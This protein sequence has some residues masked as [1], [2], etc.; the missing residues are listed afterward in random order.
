M[1]MCDSTMELNNILFVMTLLLYGAASMKSQAYFNKTGELPCHFTNSQNISLDELVVFWQD[2]DKLVLYELYR[3][4]EN[5]QNVHRK[6]KGRTSFD[7][8]NWTLRLHN[9]QIKD[10][11]LYQCFVH[12][13]GPKG[14]VPMHQM[15]SD[16]S[17]LANFSQPEIMVTS[18]RT[19]NSGIINLTCSSIQGYP[20]PK[21]MY[22]LVKT[23]N[24][25]TKYDTV[26]KKSQNNVT[27]LYNVSISLSFSVPEASNVSIFCV[28]Q[29]ESMKLPSLPYNI[30]AHTKPTPDG[31]HILWIAALLVMLVILCGMVFFLTLRKRKKKQPGPSHEC[32]T[33]KVERKESE[34][35]K[36]R[37]R[38]HE[39]ERSDEAQC[40]NISKTASGDNSTT[41]F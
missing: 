4:K 34:Q 33:N 41:Q 38:Y 18:N 32:E 6:Y 8:D 35:T 7:K 29:L 19:E 21:E 2:Q 11:G 12:H 1:G 13:K 9:I 5:P 3:G 24:S 17:V 15:N 30:D 31:D 27:E 23:E 10:K 28:L 40:V 37:V 39:T 26:M 25:S 22:F 20:E 36:E 14:L 16:L